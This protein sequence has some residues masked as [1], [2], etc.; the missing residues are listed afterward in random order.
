MPTLASRTLPR[1]AVYPGSR[2]LSGAS[3]V[4]PPCPA[5]R[6]P[7]RTIAPR[8]ARSRTRTCA[9]PEK[10]KR[11]AP[12]P[13]HRDRRRA[14]ARRRPGPIRAPARNET[15]G[16]ALEP[17][18][19]KRSRSEARTRRQIIALERDGRRNRIP[20]SASRP[21][22]PCSAFPCHRSSQRWPG[23][24]CRTECRDKTTAHPSAGG[25]IGCS[26]PCPCPGARWR[27]PC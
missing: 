14:S 3:D 7:P 19:L 13:N 12:Q 22:R 4:A 15:D 1:V 17:I 25:R 20:L 16:R 10:A 2:D 24:T 26:C 21:I 18:A 27:P 8:I 9:P 6:I 11:L 5:S 23:L